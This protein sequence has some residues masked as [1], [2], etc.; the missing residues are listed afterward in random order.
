MPSNT[1]L[2][3]PWII[4]ILNKYV[5]LYSATPSIMQDVFEYLPENGMSV[6]IEVY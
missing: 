4:M 5:V 6:D 2:L 3:P 1:L